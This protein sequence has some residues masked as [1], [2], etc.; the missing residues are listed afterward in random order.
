MKCGAIEDFDNRLSRLIPELRWL[1]WESS[2]M[3]VPKFS[4]HF[5]KLG[6][7]PNF[8]NKPIVEWDGESIY[9]EL[10]VVRLIKRHDFD[11][12]W[13]DSY[14]GKFWDGMSVERRL[15][16]VARDA[17]E[18][19]LRVRGGRRGGFWD[20]MAWK[21][22]EFIFIELK[23]NTAACKD[24][25]SEKQRDWLQAALRAGFSPSCFFVCEWG[26]QE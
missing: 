26:Y 20:V 4:M 25:I 10:A 17:Y 8:G 5:S 12:V 9:P 6:S 3:M 19:I 14:R 1:G 18:S 24:R 21:E 13:V 2:E 16:D 23:Q 15:P 7:D 22:S 11:G